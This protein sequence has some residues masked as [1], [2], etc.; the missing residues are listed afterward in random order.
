MSGP[1][2]AGKPGAAGNKPEGERDRPRHEDL[3]AWSRWVRQ[4]DAPAGQ[5]RPASAPAS[6]GYTYLSYLIG[7]ML[8]YGGIGWLVGRWTDLPVLFP[9]GMIVGLALSIVMIIF[10]VTRS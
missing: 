1:P 4:R 10:R 6:M 2:E 9:V 7:G 3:P 8:L 5:D